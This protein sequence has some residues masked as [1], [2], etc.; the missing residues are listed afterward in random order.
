MNE[1]K[2]LA[3]LGELNSE[4]KKFLNNIIYG[5]ALDGIFR[6]FSYIFTDIYIAALRDNEL[7]NLYEDFIN[8]SH[9]YKTISD[10][11]A[12]ELKMTDEELQILKKGGLS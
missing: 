4:D 3:A 6:S 12:N 9:K 10:E 2:L 7:I 11:Q 1:S 5:F 8:L